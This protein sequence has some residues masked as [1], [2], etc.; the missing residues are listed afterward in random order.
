MHEVQQRWA[1]TEADAVEHGVSSPGKQGIT[2][3]CTQTRYPGSGV[4]LWMP[5]WASVY[6][7]FDTADHNALIADNMKANI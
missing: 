2:P 3:V 5:A 7:L 4:F 1:L 6:R